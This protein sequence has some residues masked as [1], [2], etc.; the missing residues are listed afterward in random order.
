MWPGY[1][2]LRRVANR[3]PLQCTRV[4]LQLNKLDIVTRLSARGDGMGAVVA[5]RTVKATVIF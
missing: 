2:R 1:I 5:G 3:T 4:S